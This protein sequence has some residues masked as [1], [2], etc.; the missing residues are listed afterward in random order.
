M[1]AL[2]YQVHDE[3]NSTLLEICPW[4]IRVAHSSLYEPF[5]W[6]SLSLC[7]FKVSV[8]LVAACV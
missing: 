1:Y 7:P 6:I 5:G 4:D 8:F 2:G 3:G